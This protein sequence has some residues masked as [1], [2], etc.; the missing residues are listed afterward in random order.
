MKAIKWLFKELWGL[1]KLPFESIVGD[2]K[3]IREV[4][5]RHNAGE[6]LFDPEKVAELKSVFTD[7]SLVGYIKE[8]WLWLLTILFAGIM[9][10][11]FA[12]VYYQNVCNSLIY[13]NYILPTLN[14]SGVRGLLYY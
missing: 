6:R 14:A 12:A 7:F 10:W 3:A 13:E 2:L 1:I 4:I 11:L 5:R 9:G 8:N